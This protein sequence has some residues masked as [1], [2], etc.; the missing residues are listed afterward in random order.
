MGRISSKTYIRLHALFQLVLAVYLTFSRESVGGPEL[1]YKVRDKLRIDILQPFNLP[2][3]PFAY[4][5]ILLLSF[6]LFDLTLAIKLPTLNHV[7]A[8]AEFIHRQQLRQQQERQQRESLLQ[9]RASSSSTALPPP[10]ISRSR[11]PYTRPP[12]SRSSST[13]S[14]AS[15]D[16]DSS[17]STELNE[18]ALKITAEFS[19][20]YRQLCILLITLRS[21][22]FMIVSL[23]IYLS[24]DTEW[25]A[26]STAL[27]S[28]AT[29]AGMPATSTLAANT[30]ATPFQSAAGKTILWLDQN[31]HFTRDGPNTA[32][33]VSGS[34]L[35]YD[36]ND[37]K[38]KIVLGYGVLELM[39]SCWILFALRHEKKQ[40]EDQLRAVGIGVGADIIADM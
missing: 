16:S 14:T 3:S 35:G 22:I 25:G 30:M 36:V 23:Q 9:S 13:S 5:G 7:L 24:S 2:R 12:A 8:V 38:R 40:A 39:F 11:L 6:A 33:V 28:T 37:L 32:A 26:A 29:V 20:L 4:C 21:W 15:T 1:V 10:I 34:A 19:S 18:A 17:T 27:P 31:M